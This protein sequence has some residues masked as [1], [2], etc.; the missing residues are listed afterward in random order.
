M[1]S[2]TFK[3]EK[4]Y[5]EYLLKH[6]SGIKEGWFYDEVELARYFIKKYEKEECIEIYFD[7]DIEERFK[8]NLENLLK[9]FFREIIFKENKE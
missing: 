9:Q 3:L 5:N 1:R 6:Q 2:R 8:K 7:K 4:K